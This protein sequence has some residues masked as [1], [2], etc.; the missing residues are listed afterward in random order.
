MNDSGHYIVDSIERRSSNARL[1]VCAGEVATGKNRQLASV[2]A[3]VARDSMGAIPGIGEAVTNPPPGTFSASR[4]PGQPVDFVSMHKRSKV[5]C[6][7]G[8]NPA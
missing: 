3:A 2:D 7:K 5:L 1:C 6:W 4:P 8:C